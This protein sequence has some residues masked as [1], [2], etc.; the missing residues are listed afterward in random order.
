[1]I[2]AV[3]DTNVLVSALWS[4]DVKSPPMRVLSAFVGNVFTALISNEIMIEYADVLKRPKFGFD[5]DDVDR[6]LRYFERH[7]VRVEPVESALSFPD[8]DDKVFYCTALA[9]DNAKVVTGNLKHYPV[10]P[11]VVTPAQFCTQLEIG[12]RAGG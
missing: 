9:R 1:M 7:A 10:S 12:F 3:I 5:E 6:L 2:F 4:Q 11:I 8:A